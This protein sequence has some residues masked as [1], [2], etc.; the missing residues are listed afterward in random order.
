M[1]AVSLYTGLGGGPTFSNAMLDALA[2]KTVLDEL[3]LVAVPR[4]ARAQ[5]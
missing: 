3:R 5:M 2:S 4:R 1:A